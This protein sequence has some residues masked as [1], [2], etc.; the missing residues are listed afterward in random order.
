MVH[1]AHRSPEIA[2]YNVSGTTY[3][4]EGAIF[5]SAGTQVFMPRDSV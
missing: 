2:E 1:S 5:D 4:P 3:A